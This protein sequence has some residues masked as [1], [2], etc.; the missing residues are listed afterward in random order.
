M[1]KANEIINK[2]EKIIDF[3]KKNKNFIKFE[4]LKGEINKLEN[5][6]KSSI[7]FD[8]NIKKIFLNKSIF[9]TLNKIK[10]FMKNNFNIDIK[11]RTTQTILSSITYYC[12]LKPN[13][14]QEIKKKIEENK[15]IYTE[16]PVK[17]PTSRRRAPKKK[18]IIKDKS[19]EDWIHYTPEELKK[20]LNNLTLKQ[21]K[22]L[23]KNLLSSSEK[24]VKKSILIENIINKINRLK[25]HY[26]MGPG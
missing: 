21:I 2:F 22:P 15:K 24:N 11:E 6:I 3:L 23:I 25:T 26:Q 9:P 7:H 13:L 14:I 5:K 17:K 1:T 19:W 20:H 4:A 10:E 18:V 12:L 8:E 16:K